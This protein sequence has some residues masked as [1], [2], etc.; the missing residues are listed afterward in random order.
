[1]LFR[2]IAL[3]YFFSVSTQRNLRLSNISQHYITCKLKIDLMK[4][5]GNPI[6]QSTDL[7]IKFR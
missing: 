7:T 2:Y 4:I 1:M 5:K 3:G 6:H